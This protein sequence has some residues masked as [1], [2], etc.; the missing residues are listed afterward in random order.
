MKINLPKKESF[1]AVLWLPLEWFFL[2]HHISYFIQMHH[3]PCKFTCDQSTIK[4]NLLKEKGTF[5]VYLGLQRR[6]KPRCLH[7]RCKTT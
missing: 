5:G 3:E 2:E 6:D 7:A 4:G 1:S